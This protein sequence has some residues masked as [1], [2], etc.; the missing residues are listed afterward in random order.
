MTAY[1]TV[2]SDLIFPAFRFDSG[3]TLDELCLHLTT[4]GEPHRDAAGEIDNAVLLLHGTTGA[5]QQFL[6]ESF[7]GELFGPGQLL[8]AS[9]YYLVMPDGIGHGASSKPSDDLCGRF[10]RYRYGDMV[11]AQHGLMEILGVKRWRLVLGTSMGG[12]HTW[13]WGTCYPEAA[14]ALMPLACL[15]VAIGGRNR[16]IRRM[17]MD[18]IRDDPDW[19]GGEYT[20]QPRGLTQALYGLI[21]MVSSP[22]AWQ[23]EAPTREA[24]DAL[25]DGMLR[26]Y[27]GRFDANDMLYQF[28]ASE[29]YDPAPHLESI[30]APLCAVNFADD[31]VNP[32]ELGILEAMIARVERGRA[33]V[34]PASRETRGHR[35]HSIA[36]LW[37]SH[38]AVLL[39][40]AV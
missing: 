38:L 36:A 19:R 31:A 8:D 30:R 14:R 12:M 28:A 1:R 10:P 4:L 37:K 39:T 40:D 34:L 32:P 23:R 3:E 25:F 9:R 16:M 20:A 22:D 6:G 27:L 35:S 5:G 21:F 2:E 26:D 24:A 29:D 13:L 17:V 33:V 15:P 11:R 7:A 18:A